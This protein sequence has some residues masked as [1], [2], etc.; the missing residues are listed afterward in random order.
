MGTPSLLLPFSERRVV[1]RPE[2][3]SVRPRTHSHRNGDA[4]P[5]MVPYRSQDD[6]HMVMTPA[7]ATRDVGFST[8]F[9]RDPLCPS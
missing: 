7:A 8:P 1:L 3:N 4:T 5:G 9:D 6:I 2:R